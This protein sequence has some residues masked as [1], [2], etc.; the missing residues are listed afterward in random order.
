[1]E[2]LLFSGRNSMIRSSNMV[3]CWFICNRLGARWLLWC[4]FTSWL[5]TTIGF[6]WKVSIC[7]RWHVLGSDALE[8]C[9][10][11]L[12]LH[13]TSNFSPVIFSKRETSCTSWGKEAI[14][15]RTVASP[16]AAFSRSCKALI[17]SSVCT[18][19]TKITPSVKIC[20]DV[21]FRET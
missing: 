15:C 2:E 8:I 21:G 10:P 3:P 11:S 14:F 19:K 12:I 20:G 13:P 6:W 1:M 5:Q 16:D 7:R 9:F 4:L 17:S 18:K